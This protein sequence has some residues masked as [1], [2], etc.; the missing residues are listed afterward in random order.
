MANVVNKIWSMFNMNTQDDDVED[1]DEYTEDSQDYSRG[2]EIDDSS[3]RKNFGR[4]K[5]YARLGAGS[6][7]N[8]QVKVVIMQPTDFEQSVEICD[9]VRQ[10]RSVIVNLEYVN[11]DIARRIIDVVS[12]ATHVLDGYTK[13]IANAIF[14][15][16]PSNYDIDE[17]EAKDEKSS[18]S[19]VTSWLK[20]N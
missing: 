4:K 10:G 6:S 9:L 16:A 15:I 2:V 20:N 1:E 19:P 3:V 14:L 17:T 18:K 12:G 8:S 11:K 13:K 5:E 7:Y